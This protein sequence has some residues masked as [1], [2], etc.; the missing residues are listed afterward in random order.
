MADIR[1]RCLMT[2]FDG[3]YSTPLF[4]G[5]CS[6]FAADNEQPA[7][8]NL[9]T[10][11]K[12]LFSNQASMYARYRPSYP[13]ELVE[14]IVSFVDTKERVWDCATGNGQAALL[15]SPH[16]TQVEAT[17]SSE[18]QLQ[19]AVP[20]GNIHY[21]V[22]HAEQTGFPDNSFDLITV[23]QAYHWFGFDAFEKEVRRVAKP[24]AVIAVWGYHIP[25]CG[26]TA[27]NALISDFYTGTVGSYWDAERKYVDDYYRTIPFPYDALPAKEFSIRVSWAPGDLTGYLSSWSS[28]Q[29]FIKANGYNPVEEVA[30]RLSLLWPSGAVTGAKAAGAFTL[31]FHF[32]V[33]MR[34]GRI[35]G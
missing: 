26:D 15:L 17:D 32:P 3:R 29:H 9:Y 34:L 6:L 30:G 14:Y 25:Q 19:Q 13:E 10:M 21:S 18:K 23:A 7:T 1:R 22:S 11:S 20:A 35:K 4:D 5:R 8:N 16:F 12:D 2:L 28:V 33:F 24:G 31:P 27:I